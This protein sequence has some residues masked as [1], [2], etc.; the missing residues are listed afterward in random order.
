MP[1]PI[2][3]D[4]FRHLAVVSDPSVAPDGS[5]AAYTLSWIDPATSESRSRIYRVDLPGADAAGAPPP[6]PSLLPTAM[7]TPTPA[8]LPTGP[9]WPFCAPPPPNRNPNPNPILPARSG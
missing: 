9:R 5:R 6:Q 8:T 7:R 2:G 4:L 3:P 1:N